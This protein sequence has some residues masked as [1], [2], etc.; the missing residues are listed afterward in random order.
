MNDLLADPGFAALMKD[1]G[2]AITV[3][4]LDGSIYIVAADGTQT[5]T[6]FDAVDE[7]SL[8]HI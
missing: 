8:I 2:L 4:D 6:D 7:L 5:Q 3:T 1:A